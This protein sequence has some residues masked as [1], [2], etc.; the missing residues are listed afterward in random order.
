MRLP[1]MDDGAR[2]ALGLSGGADS[3]ALLHKLLEHG[4][5]PIALHLNH[6]FTDENGDEAEAFCR[7]LCAGLGVPIRVG[8]APGDAGPAGGSKEARARGWR[9]AFFAAE[10]RAVGAAGLFLA[11]QADDRAENLVLR[12]ARGCGA[13]GLTS[14]G[15]AGRLPG[16]SDLRVWRPLLDETH[17]AQVAW[18]RARGLPWVEDVSNA[19]LTIPRNAIRRV[20]APLLPHFVSGANASADLLA[21]ESACLARLAEAAVLSRSRDVLRLRPGVDPVL[22][23]RAIRAWLAPIALTRR[24]V[25][26][27]LALPEGTRTQVGGATLVRRLAAAAWRRE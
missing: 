16:T 23:R 19:D 25:E 1:G 5:R 4:V 26:A 18:L 15:V 20:L 3:T 2:W 24:Q 13:E 22:T 9:M 6:G 14:F 10:M 7:E 21:E 17:A 27:L 8:R 11:H 12:L